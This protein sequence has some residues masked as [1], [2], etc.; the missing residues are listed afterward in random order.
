VS[1]PACV[2]GT[3]DSDLQRGAATCDEAFACCASGFDAL[4]GFALAP[5]VSRDAWYKMRMVQ[6]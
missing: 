6:Q 4:D 5:V 3:L 1:V 2:A